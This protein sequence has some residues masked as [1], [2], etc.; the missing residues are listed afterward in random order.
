MKKF[1]VLVAIGAYVMDLK[2]DQ[3]AVCSV[4]VA[5][6][7]GE[8]LSAHHI[9]HDPAYY[10]QRFPIN[11]DPVVVNRISQLLFNEIVTIVD[12]PEPHYEDEVC[13]RL[14]QH[15]YCTLFDTTP[16][17]TYWT[18]KKNL[19]PLNQLKSNQLPAPIDYRTPSDRAAVITLSQPWFDAITRQ[20]YAAGTRFKLC[21]G[22]KKYSSYYTVYSFTDQDKFV[23]IRI[24]KHIAL[25]TEDLTVDE[26]I[27]LFVRLLK[28][29]AHPDVGY[30]SYA[31]GGM[32]VAD[33]YTADYQEKT[34]KT[35][36]NQYTY[37]SVK[38]PHDGPHS[39]FDCSS[40]IMR[41]AQMAGL[42]FYYRNT[43]AINNVLRP[44]KNGERIEPGDII[45]IRGHVMV[46]VDP[47]RNRIVEARTQT[48]GYG[49]VHELPIKKIFA[50]THTINDVLQAHFTKN[51]VDRLDAKGNVIAQLPVTILKLR[52]I[53]EKNNNGL[54]A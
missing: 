40:L 26:R 11:G 6:L 54:P 21:P 43:L 12:Q 37:I 31:W 28:Q 34:I 19:I 33:F 38:K 49:R 3:Q 16:R 15:Y 39:G 30:I 7:I 45:S 22:Q 42:P 44:L 48:H 46:I 53:Y 8:P 35:K 1:F 47:H 18:L 14:T 52:S 2:A 51:P 17:N 23:I 32:S 5:D 36:N 13:V 10:Y 27:A 24:P 29:Y 4:P 9:K 41:L 50:Q 25:Q 20:R